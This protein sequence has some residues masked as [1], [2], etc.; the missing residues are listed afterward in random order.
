MPL[1]ASIHTDYINPGT[2]DAIDDP[3]DAYIIDCLDASAAMQRTAELDGNGIDAVDIIDET[4]I[5]NLDR[6]FTAMRAAGYTV[7]VTKGA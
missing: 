3:V 4:A 6:L 2:P 1:Y 5:I 7:V